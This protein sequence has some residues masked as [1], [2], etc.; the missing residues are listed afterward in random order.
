M[1][2]AMREIKFRAWDKSKRKMIATG[3]HI[4]GETT[5]FNVLRGYKIAD[6]DNIVVMQ[7]TGL[8]DKNGAEIWEGDIIC[9]NPGKAYESRKQI[10]FLWGSFVGVDQWPVKDVE[11]DLVMRFYSDQSEEWEVIGNI[12]ENPELLERRT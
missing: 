10:R 4:I 7:Y 3:F 1:E 6:Y 11:K 5:V 12:Y 8:E 9:V 2:L